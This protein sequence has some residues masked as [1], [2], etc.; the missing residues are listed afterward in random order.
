MFK[1]PLWFCMSGLV[2]QNIEACILNGKDIHININKYC[3]CSKQPQIFHRSSINL[4]CI[5]CD[6]F[7]SCSS[8]HLGSFTHVIGITVVKR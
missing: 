2:L 3:Y 7:I 4:R 8:P 5:Y 1:E 6:K